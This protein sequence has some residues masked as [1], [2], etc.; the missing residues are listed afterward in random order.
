ME[1]GIVDVFSL[2]G[3]SGDLFNFTISGKELFNVL[4]SSILADLENLNVSSRVSKLLLVLSR[5]FSVSEGNHTTSK[6]N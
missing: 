6:L 3:W 2:A 4:R 1:D 5:F